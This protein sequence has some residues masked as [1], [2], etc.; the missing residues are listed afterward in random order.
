MGRFLWTVLA[1]FV[2]AVV[3]SCVPTTNALEP[4]NV[5]LHARNARIYVIRPNAWVYS[6]LLVDIKINGKDVGALAKNSYLSIDRPP[7]RYTVSAKAQFSLAPAE[8]DFKAI[9]GRTYYFVVNIKP[10][11]VGLVGGGFFTM[12][13]TATGKPI[14]QRNLFSDVYLAE[15]DAAAGA[16]ALAATKAH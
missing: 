2:G 3:A 1:V 12:P 9:G 14:D 13:G 8:H 5:A 11:T 6:A 15:L 10:T 4:Q 7:G 16:A